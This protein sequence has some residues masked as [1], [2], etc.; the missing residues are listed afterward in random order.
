MIEIR[1][2]PEAQPISCV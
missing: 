1:K 2:R